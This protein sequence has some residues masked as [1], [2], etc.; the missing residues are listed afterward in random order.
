MPMPNSPAG[1]RCRWSLGRVPPSIAAFPRSRICRR[2]QALCVLTNVYQGMEGVEPGEVKWLRINEALPRYWSTGRRWNPSLSSSAWKAALWP[3]V[4]WGVV[5]V[6]K[7]GSAHFVVPA[8]RSIFY[9]AL[10]E[11]FREIAARADLCELR[12]GR[13]PLLH[14]LSRAVE[15]HRVGVGRRLGHAAGVDPAAEHSPAATVRSG[16]ERRQRPCGPGDPLSHRYPADLRRQVRLVPRRRT[17][18]PADCG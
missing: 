12:A 18:R 15:P 4:Q 17:T 7:D 11:N 2:N 10:D 14:G 5:P 1:I 8:D 9:Q 16:R 3:R 6:E 13:G